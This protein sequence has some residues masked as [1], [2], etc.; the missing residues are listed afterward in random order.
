MED[1][2][3]RS[4]FTPA[5]NSFCFQPLQL[6]SQRP[7]KLRAPVQPR[8]WRLAA[9]VM[10]WVGFWEIQRPCPAEFGVL[11]DVPDED[12]YLHRRV[13]RLLTYVLAKYTFAKRPLMSCWHV[14]MVKITGKKP[15]ILTPKKHFCSIE[16][17]S[18]SPGVTPLPLRSSFSAPNPSQLLPSR[19]P[20]PAFIQ[21]I[22]TLAAG[23]NWAKP[24]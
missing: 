12:V 23:I 10:F 18:S 15:F 16:N 19:F 7:P 2:W 21:S 5:E 13:V 22:F 3:R 17:S 8:L 24:P 6:Q 20:L 4:Y 14:I 9:I 11:A 1:F